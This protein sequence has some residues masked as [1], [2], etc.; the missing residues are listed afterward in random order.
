MSYYNIGSL[1]MYP[2]IYF[3]QWLSCVV[4]ITV[5]IVMTI[6]IIIIIVI[7]TIRITTIWVKRQ[8]SFFCPFAILVCESVVK[9]PNYQLTSERVIGY[10]DY[11]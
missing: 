2:I 11:S 4:I 1:C 10:S 6:P 3:P 8:Q 5:I 9:P 7:S